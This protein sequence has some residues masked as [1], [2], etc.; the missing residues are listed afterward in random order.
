MSNQASVSNPIDKFVSNTPDK[1]V[2]NVDKTLVRNRSVENDNSDN[3]MQSL[4]SEELSATVFKKKIF[5]LI[6]DTR[7]DM[8]S[9]LNLVNELTKNNNLLSDELKTTKLTLQALSE[10]HNK[11][12]KHINQIDQTLI[13]LSNIND[14]IQDR[15]QNRDQDQDKYSDQSSDQ[16]D[17]HSDIG[18]LI[19]KNSSKNNV[20]NNVKNNTNPKNNLKNNPKSN[21][22]NSVNKINNLARKHVKYESDEET[23]DSKSD[24]QD[25]NILEI[26][27]SRMG[28]TASKTRTIQP[29]SKKSSSDI[30]GATTIIHRKTNESESTNNQHNREDQNKPTKKEDRIKPVKKEDKISPIISRK[31]IKMNQ[32]QDDMEESDNQEKQPKKFIHLRAARASRSMQQQANQPISINDKRK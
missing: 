10:D 3:I 5:N 17:D 22:K 11:L 29:R 13:N 28:L 16:S 6:G 30:I 27:D 19:N 24:I 4:E 31:N 12:I 9:I 18:K 7:T 25:K 14:Q 8:L 20:K 2:L 23:E 21:Q 26:S 15:D 1:S 32:D